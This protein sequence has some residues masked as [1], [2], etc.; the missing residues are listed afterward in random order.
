MNR[1]LDSLLFT[2][3]QSRW[4]EKLQAIRDAAF[5]ATY[6]EEGSPEDTALNEIIRNVR[7]RKDG[8]VTEYTERFDKVT[9]APEQLRVQASERQTAHAH[10]D[11]ALLKSLRQAIKNVRAY[12][13]EIFVGGESTHPGIR[14]NPIA[15]VGICVPGASAPLPSTVVMTAVP[16]LVAGVR[17]IALMSPPRFHIGPCDFYAIWYPQLS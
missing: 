6:F 8:A 17:E 11:P 15:R 4:H 16:A 9:L 3:T 2:H 1:D 5:A 13:T 14:Y 10:T 7:Q 12:Q